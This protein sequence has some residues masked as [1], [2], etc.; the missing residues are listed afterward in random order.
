V[1]WDAFA[2]IA[3][4]VGAAAVLVT[5]VYLARQVR[6]ARYEQ[7]AAAIRANRN[8]RRQ[9]FETSRDSAY[10]PAIHCKLAAGE[11]LDPEEA[12]RLV[13][14]NAALWGLLYSEWVQNQ[15]GLSG[16]YATSVESNISI[17][18]AQPGAEAWFERFGRRLYPAR[19]A[20]EV[21]R[22][23]AARPGETADGR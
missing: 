12:Y 14:H 13:A 11:A 18:A 23:L 6:H 17:A 15:L 9:F 2:A 4:A 19:F 10:L 3:E 8:E 21:E 16:E 22:L 5:L 1:N 20:T 7:Q